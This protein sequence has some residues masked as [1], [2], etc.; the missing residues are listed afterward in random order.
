MATKYNFVEGDCPLAD[1]V[2]PSD[3]DNSV[4][5]EESVQLPK[6]REPSKRMRLNDG[7][8]FD[9]GEKPKES[10]PLSSE[11]SFSFGESKEVDSKTEQKSVT[12]SE[13]MIDSEPDPILDDEIALKKNDN[14]RKGAKNMANASKKSSIL[15]GAV[16]LARGVPGK[17]FNVDGTT[18]EGSFYEGVGGTYFAKNEE[19]EFV[20]Y[21]SP[22]EEYARSRAVGLVVK[23]RPVYY[24]NGEFY[25]W[26]TPEE[27][28]AY[29][30]LAR[31]I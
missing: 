31:R 24:K 20:R 8:D 5:S 21:V 23:E 12:E 19:G 11:F 18:E 14:N 7:F 9:F 6:P 30:E 22:Y 17:E 16:Q 29:W 1:G 15:D 2:K 28:A 25:R 27:E 10:K 3:L 13:L 26:C 4:G